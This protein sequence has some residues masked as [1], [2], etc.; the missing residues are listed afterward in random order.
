MDFYVGLAQFKG[1]DG[2]VQSFPA[3][4]VPEQAE[5]GLVGAEVPGTQ[6]VGRVAVLVPPWPAGKSA[7]AL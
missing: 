4:H 7:H 5:A 6:A 2:L 1:V 3:L